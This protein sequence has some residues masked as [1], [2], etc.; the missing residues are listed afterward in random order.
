MAQVMVPQLSRA[1]PQVESV[2]QIQGWAN[3]CAGTDF[4]GHCGFSVKPVQ[5][6]RCRVLKI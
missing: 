6:P 3:I 2:A 4:Q 1:R 5:S